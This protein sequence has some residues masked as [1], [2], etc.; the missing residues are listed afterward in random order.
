MSTTNELQLD[1]GTNILLKNCKNKIPESES[2]HTL[3]ELKKKKKCSGLNKYL[4]F[5]KSSPKHPVGPI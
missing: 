2:C 5:K 1:P 4:S 3:P